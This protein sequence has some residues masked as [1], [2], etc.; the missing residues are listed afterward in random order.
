MFTI[1]FLPQIF[2][3]ECKQK[4]ASNNP[5]KLEVFLN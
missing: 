1:V 5:P 3:P 4:G 2:C